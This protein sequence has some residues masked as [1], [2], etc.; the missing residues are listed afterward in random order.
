MFDRNE[1]RISVLEKEEGVEDDTFRVAH[2]TKN[3]AE[4][5]IINEELTEDILDICLN[6]LNNALDIIDELFFIS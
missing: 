3:S 2:I 5:S 6:A 4:F 1:F